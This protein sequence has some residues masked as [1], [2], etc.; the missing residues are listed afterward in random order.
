[1]RQSNNMQ[2]TRNN[3]IAEKYTCFLKEALSKIDQSYYRVLTT[4]DE[5]VRERVFCYEFYHQMRLCE[6]NYN[7][8]KLHAEI[9]KSGHGEFKTEDRKNPD[10]IFHNP[11]TMSGNQ[12]IIEVKGNI[13][14]DMFKDFETLT[15][16]CKDYQYKLGYFILFGNSLSVF[17][18]HLRRA[19]NRVEI[20]KYSG[21]DNIIVICKR[22]ERSKAEVIG[23]NDLIKQL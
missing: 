15:T 22:N 1:M 12:V 7:L 2:R 10:F 13:D 5:I 19:G 23:L 9:D 11:G 3:P 20:V 17:K 4:Y 21:M 8:S 18:H 6:E 14:G 16:F